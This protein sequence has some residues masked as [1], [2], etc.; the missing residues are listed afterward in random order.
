MEDVVR[1]YPALLTPDVCINANASRGHRIS[2]QVTP[3]IPIAMY[4]RLLPSCM[5]ANLH[6]DRAQV[7]LRVLTY[8]Q[9]LSRQLSYEMV[10]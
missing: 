8:L 4:S 7:T 5:E 10:A 3:P 6:D 1:F 9:Y 2:H